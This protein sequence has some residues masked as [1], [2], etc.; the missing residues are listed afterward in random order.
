MSLPSSTIG[1]HSVH[2]PL[3]PYAR[4]VVCPPSHGTTGRRKHTSLCHTLSLVSV[5]EATL[6]TAFLPGARL[7]E[8]QQQ[9]S[10]Q[11][12]QRR[13]RLVLKLLI[14]CKSR[15]I[16]RAWN[17]W[18]GA[19]MLRRR[20]RSVGRKALARWCQARLLQV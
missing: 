14:A 9:Q 12:Q 19:D 7:I 8:E 16:V 1:E 2:D 17:S 13:Q 15:Q 10:E 11:H 5:F 6:D 3:Y 4:V 18:L 20:M